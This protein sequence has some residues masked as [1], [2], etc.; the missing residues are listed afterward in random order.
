MA[1]SKELQ[2]IRQKIDGIDKEIQRLI[3]E[4]ASCAM[5]VAEIKQEI[6]ASS[7]FYRPER[8]A[9]VLRNVKERNQGPF[10]ASDMARLFREIM[11]SCLALEEPMNIA[12]LGPEGTFTQGAAIKHFGHAVTTSPL[13]AIDEV[14]RE[15]ESGCANY[16]V[17]PIENSTEGVVNH[18]LDT[19]INSPLKVCGEVDMRIHH[20]LLSKEETLADIKRVYAHQQALAQ[21][22]EWLNENLPHAEGIAVNSNAEAAKM[23]TKESGSA[24]IASSAA[25]E[26]YGLDIKVNNIEDEPDNTTRFLVIGR[27]EVPAS[28]VDKTSIMVSAKNQSGALAALLQPLA[29]N[30]LSLSRIESRPSRR[31]NWEYVFFMDIEGHK[32]D[33]KV[34]KALASIEKEA[35]ILKVLG[36]YPVSAL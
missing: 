26:L 31:G 30:E 23:V 16:G 12:Y 7:Q 25:A 22:R 11:S 4:R 35:A 6:E 5:R 13:S 34:Q 33:E 18:T 1:D 17:V 21:C 29:E 10:P 8:E 2:D 28:G 19:F 9:Q 3:N 24:A 20:N 32:D 27:Q 14:F 36:S 15:V